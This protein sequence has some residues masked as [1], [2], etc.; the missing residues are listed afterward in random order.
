MF[1]RGK[2]YLFTSKGLDVI[3]E[4]DW[5]SANHILID[6]NEKMV[7]FPNTKDVD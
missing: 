2:P 5:L 7:L 1:N 4:M 3:L 6:Y